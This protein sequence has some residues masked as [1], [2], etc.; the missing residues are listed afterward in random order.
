EQSGLRVQWQDY[1]A[2][3]AEARQQRIQALAD[4]EAHQPFDLETG[5]LLRA[6]LVRSSD[7]EHYFV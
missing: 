3:P 2:L 5:P 7:L 4:S 6:C 1:S